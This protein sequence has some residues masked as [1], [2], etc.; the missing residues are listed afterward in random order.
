M[1]NQLNEG[2]KA[3]DLEHFV[4]DTFLVDTYKSKMG[5]D[6]DVSV[7]SFRVKDRL[8]ALDLMEFIERGYGF[9]LDADISSGE[10]ADG[11]YSVFVE[12]ERDHKLSER[13]EDLLNGITKL[14]GID[15]WR[16]RYHKDWQ[17]TP[18][19]KDAISEMVPSSPEAYL[20]FLQESRNTD[21]KDFLSDVLY[22]EVVFEGNIMTLHR[23]FVDGLK[24][25]VCNIG[26]YKTVMNENNIDL[27]LDEQTNAQTVFLSKIFK[28]YEV[29]KLGENFMVRRNDQSI[30]I[31]PL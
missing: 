19:S 29:V 22:D 5:E 20:M 14:T 28:N 8:P 18:Y 11:K 10:E 21:V 1:L 27:K 25:E 7:I 26:N 2:L 30:L 9:V 3:K 6:K 15:N 17:G 12:I 31:R 23:P 16:F 4:N 13:I 24:F